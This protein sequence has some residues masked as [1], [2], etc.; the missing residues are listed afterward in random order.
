MRDPFLS[1]DYI[2]RV[3]EPVL[4][5]HGTADD[6]VPVDHSRKL[7][8]LAHEPKSLVIVEGG[9][10]SDLWNRGLWPTVLKFLAEQGVTAGS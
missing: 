7:F 5:I 8:E 4:I 9:T 10:H 2:T 6:V 3:D 1:R